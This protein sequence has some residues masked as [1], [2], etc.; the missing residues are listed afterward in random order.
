MFNVTL[1]RS[2]FRK[3]DENLSKS[4]QLSHVQ[5]HVPTV[6][7]I[8]LDRTFFRKWRELL[9]QEDLCISNFLMKYAINPD[10]LTLSSDEILYQIISNLCAITIL[11][12][13]IL[14]CYN[15]LKHYNMPKFPFSNII[16]FFYLIHILYSQKH[17][18][19]ISSD[20]EILKKIPVCARV[21][22]RAL[23]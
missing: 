14:F 8:Q 12:I 10:T 6:D 19:I 7:W 2:T 11:H 18:E 13:I 23:I 20:L 16:K 22:L 9:V 17:F 1:Q 5:P 21:A 15:N 4:N 3:W